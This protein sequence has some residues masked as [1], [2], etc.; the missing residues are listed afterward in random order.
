MTCLS[1]SRVHGYVYFFLLLIK[2]NRVSLLALIEQG[3]E[4]KSGFSVVF[5]WGGGG[6]GE[7]TCLCHCSVCSMCKK[8]IIINSW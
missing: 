1:R 5:F 8:F 4:C 3:N 6:V 7:W 2:L